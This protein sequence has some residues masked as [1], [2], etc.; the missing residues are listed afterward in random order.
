MKITPYGMYDFSMITVL[1]N[2]LS[3]NCHNENIYFLG[4][5]RRYDAVFAIVPQNMGKKITSVQ[6]NYPELF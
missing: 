1:L 6:D 5:A 3:G 2:K 4:T